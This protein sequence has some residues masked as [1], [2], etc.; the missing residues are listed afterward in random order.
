M[1]EAILH[2]GS[3]AEV[4]RWSKFNGLVLGKPALYLPVY[5]IEHV[6]G[7]SL[8]AETLKRLQ[9]EDSHILYDK[10][11]HE[12]HEYIAGKPLPRKP[13]DFHSLYA[14]QAN[15]TFMKWQGKQQEDQINN[16]INRVVD[17]LRDSEGKYKDSL[18]PYN[19]FKSNHHVSVL[20]AGKGFVCPIPEP[21]SRGWVTS[22]NSLEI[23]NNE[24]L[25]GYSSMGDFSCKE[26]VHLAIVDFNRFNR[27]SGIQIQDHIVI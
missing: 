11:Q 26:D 4:Q 13:G 15:A 24:L 25:L 27:G 9:P 18:P 1:G 5:S 14:G 2:M 20:Y 6:D 3:I 23:V 12:A 17:K 10:R 16:A 21:W 8:D 22:L 19:D 7:S